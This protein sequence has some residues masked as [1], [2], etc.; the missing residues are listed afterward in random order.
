MH[1][2]RYILPLLAVALATACSD[3][4]SGPAHTPTSMSITLDTLDFGKTV[5]AE[6]IVKDQSGTPMDV[7]SLP[8]GITLESSDTTVATVDAAELTLTG[9]G[10]GEATITARYG[11]IEVSGTLPVRVGPKPP[12]K[13]AAGDF[14]NCLI[15]ASGAT[16][17]W[18]SNDF[19]GTLGSGDLTTNASGIPQLVAGNHSFSTLTA[20]YHTCA[21][22]DGEAWCWGE[23]DEGAL[24]NGDST[25]SAVPVRVAGGL[26][27]T[28][29]SAGWGHVCALTSEGKAYCWGYNGDGQ[30]SSSN[31]EVV[32]EP[33]AVNTDVRFAQIVA[34][35]DHNCALTPL[36][37]AYCW[38]DGGS[39]TLGTGTVDEQR[40]PVPVLDTLTFVSLSG[41]Y[42]NE[43]G[44]DR[45]GRAF[46]WGDNEAGEDGVGA[47]SDEP[48]WAPEAVDASARFSMLGTATQDH[49]CGIE[50]GTSQLFCWGNGMS[51]QI[52]DGSTENAASP[53]PVP[54][55]LAS[56]V[57]SGQDHTCA[58]D[59]NDDVFCWGAN[60]WGQIGNGAVDDGAV[61]LPILSPSQVENLDGAAAIRTPPSVTSAS[62]TVRSTDQRR[63]HHRHRIPR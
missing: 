9:T 5:A 55:F 38:G 43:C 41:G 6:L 60:D 44:L 15:N 48:L 57:T 63:T 53:T 25:N 11:D 4:L 33:V 40:A 37:K 52:G 34:S 36:G 30:V 3:D 28:Q 58:I 7:A 14:H 23:G 27:F 19:Y 51:G 61:S 62:L 16:V 1:G 42:Y 45:T 29:I 32:L 49:L 10:I 18:G 59:T 21:L 12:Q 47:S 35:G 26:T 46:C 39:G 13:L 54:G 31:E 8:E 17:C 20:G 24:G 22:E 56:A 50:R 2:H